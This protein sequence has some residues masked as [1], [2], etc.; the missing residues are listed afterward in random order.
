MDD[1]DDECVDNEPELAEADDDLDDEDHAEEGLRDFDAELVDDGTEGACLFI[2]DAAVDDM[3]GGRGGFLE[4][5]ASAAGSGGS[6]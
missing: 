4:A 1:A 2:A 5:I 3:P 6:P